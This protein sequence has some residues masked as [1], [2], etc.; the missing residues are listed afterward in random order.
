[1]GTVDRIVRKVQLVEQ[2]PKCPP[3]DLS[4]DKEH[5]VM[6]MEEA[7]VDLDQLE[8]TVVS[9]SDTDAYSKVNS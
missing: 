5:E 4:L 8:G 1:M 7:A 2:E 9:S 6:V 3:P